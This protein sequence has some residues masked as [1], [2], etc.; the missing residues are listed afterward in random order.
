MLLQLAA[1]LRQLLDIADVENAF[2][3]PNPIQRPTGQIFV[4]PCEGIDL[5]RGSLIELLVNVHGLD[6]APVARRR[7]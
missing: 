5:E 3:Q 1:N 2:C 7:T 6:D 4:E